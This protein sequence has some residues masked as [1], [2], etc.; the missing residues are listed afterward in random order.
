MSAKNKSVFENTTSEGIP[1]LQTRAKIAVLLLTLISCVSNLWAFFSIESNVLFFIPTLA[2]IAIGAWIIIRSAAAFAV[3]DSVFTTVSLANKG[4]LHHRITNTIGMGELGHVAW[5]LND[6]LDRIEAYFKEVNS[7]FNHVAKGSYDRKALSK[8]LPGQLRESLNSINLSIDKMKEGM[9]LMAANELHSELHNL[10]TVHLINNLKANQNDLDRISKGIVEIEAIAEENGSA[11]K[12]SSEEVETM[13]RKL[14][15]INSSI[16]NVA[17]VVTELGNDSERVSSSLSII[18]EI[19]DQTSL[20]A[21]NAA[22]EAARA[23]EQGRG[24]A[25][26]AE[27]VKALSNRTKEAA[28]EVSST[29]AGFSDRVKDMIQKAERSNESAGSMNQQVDAFKHQFSDFADSADNIQR[30]V[31]NA[32]DRTFGTL[33]KLDHIIFKQNGY[34]ALDDS[35]DRSVEV[36]AVSVDHHGCRMGHWYYQGDGATNFSHMNA[37][38]ALESPH[39]LVHSSVLKAVSLRQNNWR[40]NAEIRNQIVSAMR[41]AEE[42]SDLILE[43]IDVMMDE[44]HGGLN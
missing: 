4:N 9:D 24:F 37:Y 18:T 14:Q 26:V 21:L 29:M 15:E 6:F 19:A 22:I 8:G 10:N 33:A 13:A 25:V 31:A 17:E 40:S 2:S 42:Q 16:Q 30:N 44:K 32:K 43:N 38:G 3:I 7:C 23:G 36:K 11:A 12:S 39:A 27:E 34:L 28:I 1:F 20:L 41:T 35:E 5:E